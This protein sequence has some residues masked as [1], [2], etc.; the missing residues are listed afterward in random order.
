MSTD[1][2]AEVQITGGGRPPLLLLLA[3]KTVAEEFW[4]EQ[5]SA[6]RALVRGGYLVRCAQVRGST[7]ALSG[8]T[9]RAGALTVWAPPRISSI[10]WNGQPLATSPRGDGS[11][12]GS[13]GGPASVTLPA[14]SGWRF[15]FETPEAQPGYDDS[16]WVL[17]DHSVTT[18]PTTPV[19]TPVLYADDYGFHTGFV[20]YRGHFTAT[21]SE[22]GINL[23]VGG[24]THGAFS[25]WLNGAFLGSDTA[26]GDSTQMS[27]PFPAAA[28]RAGQDN[29]VAVLTQ[30]SGHD[31][32]GVYGPAPSDAQ[33]APRGLLGASLEGAS[34]PVTW[35]L[36]GAQGG[37]N[38]QDPV[39]GP[40]NATGLFGTNR[41]WDLPGYPDA[42]WKSVSLPDSWSGP[43]P[44]ARDRVVPD[45]VQPD[46]AAA[47][48]RAGRGP[49]RRAWP[50]AGDRRRELP[51]VHLRQRLVDGTVRQPAR[52]AAPLLR[53]GRDPPAG[54]EEHAGDRGMGPGSEWR[55]A[56]QGEAWSRWATRAE[57]CRFSRVY[58]P[59]WNPAVYG[60]PTASSPTLGV[61][62]SAALVNPGQPFTVKA[63]LN[64]PGSAPLR[65]AAV[66]LNAPAGWTVA[67]AGP[68]SLGT[69][70]PGRSVSA[71]FQVT[72]AS[73][74]SSSPGPVDL[75]A[76]STYDV[77]GQSRT[78][79][80]TAQLQVPFSSL[81]ASFDNTGITDDSDTNPIVGVRGVR[82]G[83]DDVL[84]AGPSR[85]GLAPG[86]AVSAGGLSF[87]W[88]NVPSAQP[89]NTMAEGQIIRDLRAPGASWASW[90]PRT[91]R[92]S[93][94]RAPSTTPTGPRPHTRSTW[95]TSGTRRDRAVTR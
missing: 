42:G 12:A 34:T 49:D 80:G 47:E 95:A 53:A 51:G 54:R 29:V 50:G 77:S 43:R 13:V 20:W 58:S 61:V 19:T 15:A 66:N 78:L 18:N 76:Q 45:H 10:S 44:A 87:T 65:D 37:E 33:K 26:G 57:A 40:L 38:L 93:R 2:L 73:S 69:V 84:G 68:A 56:R 71:S 74:G 41:G 75:V 27:F 88:P 7:L 4:P 91:T 52:A 21:G 32:D 59:G 92:P 3:Q 36:Q 39:R 81:A 48:L 1:G 55:R 79:L 85:A 83:G 5:T 70:A 31:E 28:L 25:V 22:T 94:A 86:A 62:S 90:P 46:R 14:L 64:N 24:G 6:G 30:S 9:S 8:D 67:P 23:T 63:T 11:L 35:R 72:P 16:N 60:P 17:A 89:D 82:R